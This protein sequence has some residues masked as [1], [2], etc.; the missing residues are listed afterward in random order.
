MNI[1]GQFEKE[2]KEIYRYRY[3]IY[4]YTLIKLKQRYRRSVLGYLW[5]IFTPMINYLIMGTV[6]SFIARGAEIQNYFFY[7]ISGSVFFNFLSNV[8][9]QSFNC[10]IGNEHFIKKIYIP[11]SIFFI[12]VIALETIN[13]FLSFST[14]YVFSLVLGMTSPNLNIFIS[15]FTIGVAIPFLFGLG[16]FVGIGAVFFRDLIHII[17]AGLQALYFLTPIL[18][19]PEMVPEELRFSFYINPFY[20]FIETF[21]R[22]LMNYGPV[23]LSYIGICV[24]FSLSSLAFGLLLLKKM[25]NRIV[26]K[27]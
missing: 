11:K 5:T 17:P 13:F 18:Y 26:F 16:I 25:E 6:I 24:A 3:L 14:L 20:Y 2:I 19:K 7:F 4:S 10:L 21:R 22:P 15:L 9:S 8:I 23:P 27:L 12:N 1:I